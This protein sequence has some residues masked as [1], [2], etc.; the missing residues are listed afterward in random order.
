MTYL[1]C[2]V[3]AT[4]FLM[5][6]KQLVDALAQYD[7]DVELE[8]TLPHERPV[9]TIKGTIEAMTAVRREQDELAFGP[10]RSCQWER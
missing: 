5:S 6:K 4:D 9:A 1:T 2:H 8:E 3:L 7:L 10:E